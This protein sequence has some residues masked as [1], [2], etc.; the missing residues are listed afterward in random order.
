[1]VRERGV[2]GAE[3]TAMVLARAKAEAVAALPEA[4]GALVVG[5]DSVFELDGEVAGETIVGRPRGGHGAELI[6][7][8]AGP[9]RA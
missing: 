5:C 4:A 8:R 3:E 6:R 2:T 9:D 7:R 1:M